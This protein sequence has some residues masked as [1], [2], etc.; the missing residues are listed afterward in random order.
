MSKSTHKPESLAER[1]WSL[2]RA[3]ELTGADAEHPDP[4]MVVNQVLAILDELDRGGVGDDLSVNTLS[5]IHLLRAQEMSGDLSYASPEQIRGEELDERSLVFSIG[6]LIFERL[7]GRHPFGAAGNPRRV[8]RISQGEFGSGVNYFPTVPP[9]LRTVLMKSMG[10]FPEERWGSVAELRNALEHF[11]DRSQPTTVRLPGT[12]EN[13]ETRVFRSGIS[14]AALAQAAASSHVGTVRDH[15]PH[16]LPSARETARI[17]ELKSGWQ[18]AAPILWLAIG[19]GAA[20]AVFMLKSGGNGSRDEVAAARPVEP[21]APQASA[22]IARP[23]ID[24]AAPAEPT[25]EPAAKSRVPSP[26]P[27]PAPAPARSPASAP[28]SAPEPEPAPE[29]APAAFSAQRGGDRAAAV[30]RECLG[31]ERIAATSGVIGLSIRYRADG[32]VHKLYYAAG[33]PLGP[34]DRTCIHDRLVDFEAGRS[35]QAQ[36][37][38]YRLHVGGDESRAVVAGSG[39]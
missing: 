14:P 34:A 39:S 29:P 28:A 11:A 20:S 27:A 30:V 16:E 3:R 36:V 31:P 23:L 25:P 6:V 32:R 7:T 35:E 18:R 19:A 17:T 24:A 12:Q 33:S 2:A 26:A 15:T 21:A 5:F 10:P 38:N 8:A 9:G 22:P 37:I 4:V 1:F 13:E